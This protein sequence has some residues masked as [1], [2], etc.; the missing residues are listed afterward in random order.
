M[1]VD[2]ARAEQL[3]SNLLQVAAKVQAASKGKTVCNDDV[4]CPCIQLPLVL[5]IQRSQTSFSHQII[6]I[7]ITSMDQTASRMG[8]V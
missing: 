7:T 6:I 4:S 5:S 2:P 1:H 3:V 8:G